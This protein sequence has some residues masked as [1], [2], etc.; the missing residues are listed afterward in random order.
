[1]RGKEIPGDK[2]TDTAAFVTGAKRGSMEELSTVLPPQAEEK[3]QLLP[4]AHSLSPR[5]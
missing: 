5:D 3:H 4:P 2:R 1:M